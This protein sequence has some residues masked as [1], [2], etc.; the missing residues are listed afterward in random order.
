MTDAWTA[1]VLGLL[2][3]L[4]TIASVELGISVALVE[5]LLG[6]LGGNLLGLHTTPWVDYLAGFGGIVLTFLAGAEVDTDVLREQLGPSLLIGGLSF[7]LPFAGAWAVA[8]WGL[9]WT[10]EASRIAG[11]A[12]STTSLAVVYAVLV[13]TGLT[14][15][16]LGKLL[17]A[18]TFVTDFGTAAALSVLFVTPT[19]W[20][21]GF[22]GVAVAIVLIMPRLQPWIFRRYGGRII[23]AEIKGAFAALLALMYLGQRSD[24]H[25]V[26]PAFVLGLAFS[27]IFATHPDTQR[28]FRVVAFAMLTPFFF[29]KAGLNVQLTAVAA[30]LRTLG[31]LFAVKVALKF[32]GVLPA[33]R[34]SAPVGAVYLTLLMSTGLTFGTISSL[35]GL[36]AGI[37]DRTQ[38]SLLVTTVIAT[39]VV[40]TL[41]AQRWFSPSAGGAAAGESAAGV[42]VPAAAEGDE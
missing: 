19:V 37:L 27:R 6:V 7:L 11:V 12:L 40:P 3:F 23:E 14:H 15:T 9:H 20:M 30:S 4:A 25:A 38:F 29:I 41:V 24:S 28:R 31:L 26:L 10:P 36:Q 34:R 18:S 35:Y 42:L 13:E 5:I 1:T 17:M 21:A 22:V 32:A 16:A 39:A 2:I 8:Q 33:A